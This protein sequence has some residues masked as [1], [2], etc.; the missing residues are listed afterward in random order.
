M[1]IPPD[2]ICDGDQPILQDGICPPEEQPFGLNQYAI[3][4]SLGD[5][6]Y[7]GYLEAPIDSYF[8]RSRELLS[9]L[10]RAV[11][12][13][14]GAR[15]SYYEGSIVFPNPYEVPG[16]EQFQLFNGFGFSILMKFLEGL[17]QKIGNIHEDLK[18]IEA[19]SSIVESYQ[20]RK[21]AGLSQAVLLFGEVDPD[22]HRIGP[23]KWQLTLPN[24]GDDIFDKFPEGFGFKKGSIQLL[25]T[26]ANNAKTFAYCADEL[27]AEYV[28]D[29][30][31]SLYPA[32]ERDRATV[33]ISECKGLPYKEV[34]VFLR[35]I[36]WFAPGT[37]RQYPN[38]TLGFPFY[39]PGY[40]P[41]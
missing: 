3:S 29:K 2:P 40:S 8:F 27:E 37:P 12:N 41:S 9:S 28:K 16:R 32:L 31:F 11:N 17:S 23:G 18:R 15:S 1:F 20:L 33:K 36:D 25:I 10:H 38:A 6:Y 34:D 7:Y 19:V 39:P 30:V 14:I 35:R 13:L 24:M 4:I 22:T 5:S 26:W 21:E